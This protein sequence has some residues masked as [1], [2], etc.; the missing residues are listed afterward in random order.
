MCFSWPLRFGNDSMGALAGELQRDGRDD[1]AEKSWGWRTRGYC[2]EITIFLTTE[3]YNWA[4]ALAGF[5]FDLIDYDVS[6]PGQTVP[7][8]N[9]RGGTIQ[10]ALNAA[11]TEFMKAKAPDSFVLVKGDGSQDVFAKHLSPSEIKDL[12]ISEG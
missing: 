1:L 4:Y 8:K 10:S 12:A 9:P 11:N 7:R 6:W 5:L 3:S 2:Y